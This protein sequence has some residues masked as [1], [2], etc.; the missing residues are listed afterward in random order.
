MS[1]TSDQDFVVFP[2]LCLIII[3]MPYKHVYIFYVNIPDTD[4][5]F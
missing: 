4:K 3:H 2:T 1:Q 5:R